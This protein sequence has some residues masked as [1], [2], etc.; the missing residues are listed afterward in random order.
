MIQQLAKL[1]PP[2]PVS[3]LARISSNGTKISSN[4]GSLSMTDLP[5]LGSQTQFE[6]LMRH[7]DTTETLA[8]QDGSRLTIE[9]RWADLQVMPRLIHSC[10]SGLGGR[11]IST[12]SQSPILISQSSAVGPKEYPVDPF[13]VNKGEGEVDILA[14]IRPVSV[15]VDQGH[16][17]ERQE[18]KQEEQA[19]PKRRQFWTEEEKQAL[20]TALA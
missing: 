12:S 10:S 3:Y 20:S 1:S 6:K 14:S 4:L 2:Q 11:G 9:Q 13:R 8:E 15:V 16:E 18:R 5:V 7:Y 19:G 17:D